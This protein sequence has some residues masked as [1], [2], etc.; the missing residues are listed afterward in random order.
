M[1]N[2]A[3]VLF[4]GNLKLERDLALCYNSVQNKLRVNH[5]LDRRKVEVAQTP[6]GPLS[7]T[8]WRKTGIK[9]PMLVLVSGI[10]GDEVSSVGGLLAFLKELEG[11][12][13]DIL[14]GSI[15]ALPFANSLG[16]TACRTE[17]QTSTRI[18]P[19]NLNREFPGNPLGDL[20]QRLAYEIFQSIVNMHPDMVID[21]HTWHTRSIPFSIIDQIEMPGTTRELVLKAARAAGYLVANDLPA[22]I[23]RQ[24]GIERSLSA[25]L[26]KEGIPAFTVE[27]PGGHFA[28]DKAVKDLQASLHGVADCLGILKEKEPTAV[29]S[30]YDR[31]RIYSRY[32]GPQA[33][34]AG[35]FQPV[36][37][38]GMEVEQGQVIGNITSMEHLVT[39]EVAS[40]ADGIVAN[41]VDI[42]V[43]SE[44]DQLFELLVPEV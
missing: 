41:I 32:P 1:K 26:L 10:H 4:Y 11:D 44:G 43:V 22:E 20:V 17:V 2:L 34:V 14:S 39:R 40:N 35:F 30:M 19:K 13:A 16:L 3:Q 18:A 31:S 23:H 36:V 33:Q 24:S 25:A 29:F 21:L 12:A 15:V 37:A 27:V 9:G 8:L 5:M 42:S 7:F 28:Q 38:P 6:L